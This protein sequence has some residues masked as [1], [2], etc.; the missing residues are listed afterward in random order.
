MACLPRQASK[1][2][3]IPGALGTTGLALALPSC[4]HRCLQ[5]CFCRSAAGRTTPLLSD[6]SC[7]LRTFWRALAKK[8]LF[9]RLAKWQSGYCA[10]ATCTNRRHKNC[11]LTRKADFLCGSCRQATH[12][13]LMC[14]FI[15]LF[16]LQG[17]REDSRDKDAGDSDQPL[18][19]RPT[20]LTRPLLATQ[21]GH[22]GHRNLSVVEQALVIY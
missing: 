2:Q 19:A 21:I 20:S 15:S 22:R 13:L 11:W 12:G 18:H 16:N 6:T 4:R 9:V 10:R 1:L 14:S 17:R 8:H 3:C 5:L 7:R